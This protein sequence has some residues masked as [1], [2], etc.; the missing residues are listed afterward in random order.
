MFSETLIIYFTMNSLGIISNITYYVE[1]FSLCILISTTL[2][3][4]SL[5][6]SELTQQPYKY[7]PNFQFLLV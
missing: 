6:L 3:I 2:F 7:C 5:L 4:P 1:S